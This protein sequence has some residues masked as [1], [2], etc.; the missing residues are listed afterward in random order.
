MVIR[1]RIDRPRGPFDIETSRGHDALACLVPHV[2]SMNPPLELSRDQ[3][4]LHMPKWTSPSVTWG[5]LSITIRN[6]DVLQVVGSLQLP[7]RAA[8][9]KVLCSLVSF[10]PSRSC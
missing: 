2:V 6:E 1:Y 8:E 9:K 5:P 10:G 3:H 7:S 4:Q